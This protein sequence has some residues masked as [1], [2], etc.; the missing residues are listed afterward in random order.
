MI[1]KAT[2]DKEQIKFL[3]F[4]VGVEGWKL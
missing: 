4:G 3:N 1:K 2:Y